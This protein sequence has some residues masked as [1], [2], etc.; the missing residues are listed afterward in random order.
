MGSAQLQLQ[1]GFIAR[2]SMLPSSRKSYRID[3]LAWIFL[4]LICFAED[5]S[6]KDI[7]SMLSSRS[8]SRVT[9]ATLNECHLV[10][11]ASYPRNNNTELY[12][13]VGVKKALR[14]VWVIDLS[15]V[16]H[17]KVAP[18]HGDMHVGFW[19]PSRTWVSKL[20]G[21]AN[22][23]GYAE[24]IYYSN[25]NA[26]VQSAHTSAGVVI[27]KAPEPDLAKMLTDYV[28]KYCS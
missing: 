19:P 5:A 22:K 21:R 28:D 18:V 15:T 16:G 20:L 13:P 2:R 6:A 14:T 4:A 7:E 3:L 26:S 12:K 25:G 11:E 1:V 24:T 27:S 9:M 10:I 17:M 23:V 8:E